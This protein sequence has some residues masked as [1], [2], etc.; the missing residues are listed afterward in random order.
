[1]KLLHAI[2]VN[3]QKA[4]KFFFKLRKFCYRKKYMYV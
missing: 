2:T 3:L 1:M 4:T